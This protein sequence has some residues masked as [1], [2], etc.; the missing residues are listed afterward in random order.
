MADQPT[1]TQ[2]DVDS[3]GQKLTEFKKTLTS[4][5]IAAM[6]VVFRS[7]IPQA[8]DVAGYSFGGYGATG[9]GV[10]TLNPQPIQ[11]IFPDPAGTTFDPHGKRS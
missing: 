9:T 6:A 4:G 1:I 10:G 11:G 8:E 5:E 3:L 2:A 7:G